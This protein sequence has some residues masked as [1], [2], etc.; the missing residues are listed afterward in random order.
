MVGMPYLVIGAN[1]GAPAKFAH[2]PVDA[3]N[4]ED[5]VTQAYETVD[6]LSEDSP[7]EVYPLGVTYGGGIESERMVVGDVI[8]DE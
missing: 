6:W 3:M 2:G 8:S 7:V 4:M 5:A 1:A